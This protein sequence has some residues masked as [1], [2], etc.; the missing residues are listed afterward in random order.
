MQNFETFE[1]VEEWLAPMGFDAFWNAVISI[2]LYDES[3][4][5]HC[6]RTLVDGIADMETVMTVTKMFARE[7]LVRQF[8]LPFR[9]DVATKPDLSVIA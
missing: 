5:A 8:D 1:D 3:D 4:R 6:D 9:C 2:G 7:A